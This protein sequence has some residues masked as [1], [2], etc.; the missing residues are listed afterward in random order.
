METIA[1]G[2]SLLRSDH[3]DEAEA[4]RLSAVGITHDLALL[5]FAVFLEKSADLFLGQLRMDARNEQVR[6]RIDGSIVPGATIILG[7]GTAQIRSL[8]G[9][10]AR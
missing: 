9:L 1:G 3:L 10:S 6:S 4:T 2:I 8:A 7:D 5:D